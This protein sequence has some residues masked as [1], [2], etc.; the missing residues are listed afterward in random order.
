MLASSAI[1]ALVYFVKDLDRTEAFY[2][3][4]LGIATEKTE[5][6][7]GPFLMAQSGEVTLVF[8]SIGT[9]RNKVRLR[10]EAP[11]TEVM[12][13]QLPGVVINFLECVEVVGGAVLYNRAQPG[14]AVV[15]TGVLRVPHREFP[16]QGTGN[17]VHGN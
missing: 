10:G 3:D 17:L 14:I 1:S 2:R 5:S 16:R 12:H 15:D 9:C 7:E 6:H 8:S 11:F 13:L 4:V